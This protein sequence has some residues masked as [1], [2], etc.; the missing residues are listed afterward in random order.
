M[1][2]NIFALPF[3]RKIKYEINIPRCRNKPLTSEKVSSRK[4]IMKPLSFCF[5]YG[6]QIKPFIILGIS[7]TMHLPAE[8]CRPH[9]FYLHGLNMGSST[10]CTQAHKPGVCKLFQKES[11][12]I[13]LQLCRRLKKIIL[14]QNRLTVKGSKYH[15]F[16]RA[17]KKAEA[18]VTSSV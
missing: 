4:L 3:Y 7:G 18:T 16:F 15:V 17:S 11:G 10:G 2:L 8:Q 12:S 9:C 13:S 1:F 14:C 5:H 6:D